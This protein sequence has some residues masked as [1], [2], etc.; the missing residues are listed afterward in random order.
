MFFSLNFGNERISTAN[1][2]DWERDLGGRRGFEFEVRKYDAD[3]DGATVREI[4]RF[5]ED[6]ARLVVILAAELSFIHPFIN[7]HEDTGP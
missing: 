6:I 2:I 3:R 5:G 4:Q 7:E 1:I